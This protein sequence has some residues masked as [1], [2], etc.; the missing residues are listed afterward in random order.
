MLP[1]TLALI[2][3]LDAA[4]LPQPLEWTEVLVN[5]LAFASDSGYEWLLGISQ[6]GRMLYGRFPE[7]S[8]LACVWS[9]LQS[10]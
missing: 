10:L 9:P 8:A 7:P 4:P 3:S 1:D 5:L 6:A 2:L